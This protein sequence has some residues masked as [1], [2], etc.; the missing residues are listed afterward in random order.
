MVTT[1]TTFVRTGDKAIR[2]RTLSARFEHTVGMTETGC[3][4]FTLSPTAA[5]RAPIR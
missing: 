2:D 1:S 3:E 4:I 5:D